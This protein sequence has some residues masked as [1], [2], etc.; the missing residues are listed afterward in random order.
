MHVH[1]NEY[2]L[3]LDVAEGISNASRPPCQRWT[4]S[5]NPRQYIVKVEGGEEGAMYLV[6]LL[7]GL[8]TNGILGS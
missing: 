3:T 4:W 1:T 7:V 5:T 6:R 2:G 8:I